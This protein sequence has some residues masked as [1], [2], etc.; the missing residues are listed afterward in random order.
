MLETFEDLISVH[1]LVGV[2]EGLLEALLKVIP[3]GFASLQGS[4][5]DCA[6][7]FV[8]TVLLPSFYGVAFHVCERCGHPSVGDAHLAVR[9][10]GGPEEAECEEKAVALCPISREYLGRVTLERTIA[11]LGLCGG[12]CRH[13]GRWICWGCVCVS[14]IVLP[15]LG[16]CRLSAPIPK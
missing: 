10:V 12:R 1:L 9:S 15:L 6:V 2:G 13:R 7:Q 8:E 16:G 4:C 5:C 11:A 3:E 14:G